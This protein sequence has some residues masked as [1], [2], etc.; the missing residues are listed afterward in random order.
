MDAIWLVV[1]GLL[2]A[3]LVM[4]AIGVLGYSEEVLDCRRLENH[5]ARQEKCVRH[6]RFDGDGVRSVWGRVQVA[7]ALNEFSGSPEAILWILGMVVLPPLAA[8]LS[9]MC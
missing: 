3:F 5:A 1:I 4:T 9:R 6:C 7:P 2:I 8:V